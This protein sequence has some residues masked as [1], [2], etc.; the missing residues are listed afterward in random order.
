MEQ[1]IVV[2]ISGTEAAHPGLDWA[3]GYAA[4]TH[5]V[6]ELVH[7]VDVSWRTTPQDVVEETLLQAE[8]KLR[9][10]VE[11]TR[12]RHPDAKLHSAAL[13]GDPDRSLAEHAGEDLLVL[14]SPTNRRQGPR[15]FAGRSTRIAR[16]AEGP[17]IVFPHET[18]PDARGVVVG[19]DGSDVSDAAVAFAA[20]EADRLGEP[21]T[22]LHSWMPPVIWSDV[23]IDWP[24]KLD[25]E[26][27]RMALGESLAGLRV[28]YPDLKVHSEMV[29][30]RP[31]DA[32][33]KAGTSARMLVV[34]SHGYGAFERAWVG[35]TS[36]ELLHTMP[37]AVA[38]VRP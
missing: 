3:V 21:L 26:Q 6:V 4:S 30:A 15:F 2:G 22:A 24:T 33:Y 25:E 32:L 12:T 23:P 8:H 38:I 11:R 29:Y 16:R 31:G 17:V 13:V 27:A 7:V 36:E 37:C 28:D 9:Q 5:A 14:G 34:G 20:R 1:R 19:V 18:D 35:S 10:V